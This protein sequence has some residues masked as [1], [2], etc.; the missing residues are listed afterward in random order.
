M[1]TPVTFPDEFPEVYMPFYRFY[2]SLI[3]FLA[4][5]SKTSAIFKELK[6]EH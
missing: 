1:F 5:A 4:I 6:A 2:R 3:T